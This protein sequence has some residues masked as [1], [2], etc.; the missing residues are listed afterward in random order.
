[1]FPRLVPAALLA[2]A[3]AAAGGPPG[4]AAE[5][6]VVA[7]VNGHD[8]LLSD[9]RAAHRR[10][11]REY[12]QV[13]FETIFPGLVDSLIDTRLAAADA[14]RQ[15]LHQQQ[16]F[17]DQ[18]ARIEDQ[19]LQRM[20]LSKI[21]EKGVS[22]ADV[23]SRFEKSAKERA[24]SKQV[25]ARHILVETEN[26]A[27]A[28]I[29]DLKK[30]G[31]FTALARERST[32]PSA[33]DGGDLG[34]FGRGQM[35]PAFEAAAFKLKKGA[36]T[37]TPVKTQFGWHV[38][39]VEDRKKAEAPS[40]EDVEQFL[41]NELSQEAGTAYIKRLRGGAKITRFNADGSPL[42]GAAPAGENKP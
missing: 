26:Q 24:A 38:I 13:P 7:T 35:V 10:L 25:K 4:F 8:I 37:E 40:F 9:V 23:R 21:I 17:K 3:L 31:D 39:L 32:G 18:M 33:S 11:P 20:M 16:E 15:N 19:I 2:L 29:A 42:E 41:R 36:F 5:D 12:Q 22:D 28:V 27:K 34:F 14:R 6:T 1:M 30:G